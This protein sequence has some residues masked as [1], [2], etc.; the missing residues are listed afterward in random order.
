MKYANEDYLREHKLSAHG[1]KRIKFPADLIC[2]ICRRTL[3][4]HGAYASHMRWHENPK[5]EPLS[6]NN[7]NFIKIIKKLFFSGFPCSKCDLIFDAE[8]KVKSHLEA[9]KNFRYTCRIIDCEMQFYNSKILAEHELR[10]HGR[11]FDEAP[12]AKQP[13][14]CDFC[15]RK[16]ANIFA[17][18][19][20]QKMH[21]YQCKICSRQLLNY[22]GWKSHIGTHEHKG[23][24]I[25]RLGNFVYFDKMISKISEIF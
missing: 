11:V 17:F 22:I 20:H 21:K 25:L 23:L 7:L 6:E 8:Y 13:F 12:V 10:A 4:N 16:M 18:K 9:H 19:K 14:T 5:N 3:G 15:D 24:K 2:R 1:I